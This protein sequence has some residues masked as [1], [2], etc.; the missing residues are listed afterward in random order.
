M[1]TDFGKIVICQY[2]HMKRALTCQWGFTDG[3]EVPVGMLFQFLILFLILFSVIILNAGRQ[4]I[5]IMT[6]VVVFFV[7]FDKKV[8]SRLFL[9]V[10]GMIGAFAIFLIFQDLFETLI[11]LSK[12]EV[13][14]GQENIR[15]RAASFY[16]TEF[17][18]HPVAYITGNGAF[19]NT[20]NYGKEIQQHMLFYRFFLGDIGLIG[21][22][23]IYGA[24]FVI[25]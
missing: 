8:K 15:F 13:S 2:M 23:A 1:R 6:L 19:A 7:V 12:R 24:F 25:G 4:T 9:I 20:S 17:F 3:G 21:N 10:L 11:T 16:L 18:K 5:A 22:Y 14:L